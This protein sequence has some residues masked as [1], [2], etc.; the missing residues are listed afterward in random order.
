MPQPRVAEEHPT[1]DGTENP[2]MAI[3]A[4]AA[5]ASAP[6]LPSRRKMTAAPDEADAGKASH[7]SMKTAVAFGRS[8]TCD[9]RQ[10]L[11]CSRLLRIQSTHQ[12]TG[13][14]QQHTGKAIPAEHLKSFLQ[15]EGRVLQELRAHPH[16]HLPKVVAVTDPGRGSSQGQADNIG[17]VVLPPVASDLHSYVRGLGG[18]S[19][20]QARLYFRQIVSAVGH[21]H[22]RNV[23]LRDIKLTKMFFRDET[24]MELV[25]ADLEGSQYLGDDRNQPLMDQRGC[26]AYGESSR[27]SAI[28]AV[29]PCHRRFAATSS[30]E[31]AHPPP[32]PSLSAVSPEVL[33]GMPYNGPA[34]DLWSLGVV[35]YVLLTGSYPFLDKRA[36]VLF[37]KIQCGWQAVHIP[38]TL[39]PSSVALLKTLL[40]RRPELRGDAEDILDHPWLQPQSRASLSRRASLDM[41]CQNLLQADQLVPDVGAGASDCGPSPVP[42]RCRKPAN[43]CIP[44]PAAD[45]AAY[46]STQLSPMSVATVSQVWPTLPTS[47]GRPASPTEASN[48]AAV[49]SFRADLGSAA[50][51]D[52]RPAL[53][54]TKRRP[55][56]SDDGEPPAAQRTKLE[57]G[58]NGVEV[59]H[60]ED[61]MVS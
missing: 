49:P 7:P 59:V 31:S 8:Y 14:V 30:S 60:Y 15:T 23:V 37:R 41:A 61:A 42:R 3:P 13:E 36:E 25:L 32:S 27:T 5:Q 35:L 34:A 44:P 43:I 47:D 18:L 58:V 11:G 10:P 45:G 33:A 48:A 40:S 20:P 50:S 52:S 56:P 55:L 28:A 38:E 17:L 19:E 22:E 53:R 51:S 29:A 4:P 46:A 21:C 57:K 12:R 2:S 54:A 24:Q 1:H 39:S 9:L 16:P 6:G 26:P